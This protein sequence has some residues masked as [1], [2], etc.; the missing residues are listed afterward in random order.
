MGAALASS[1]GFSRIQ[2]RIVHLLV[3]NLAAFVNQES[4]A[5]AEFHGHAFNIS[6]FRET[7][8]A[9][10]RASPIAEQGEG[11]TIL[12]RERKIRKRAIHAHT[13]NLGV[14]AFQLCQILLESLYFLG[15]TT[16]EGEH[17]ERQGNVLFPAVV[18]K[19]EF[20]QARPIEGQQGEIGSCIADL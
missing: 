1:D 17:I 19:R 14:G 16:G 2:G 7:V 6:L 3:N 10:H 4:C 9:G 13:Q 8:L 11:D 20:F 18:L 5:T 15:S 12:L